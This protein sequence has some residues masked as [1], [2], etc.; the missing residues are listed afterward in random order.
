MARPSFSLFSPFSSFFFAYLR[1]MGKESLVGAPFCRLC[2]IAPDTWSSLWRRGVPRGVRQREPQTK[3]TRHNQ[4]TL[5][6]RFF[7]FSKVLFSSR[8]KKKKKV[9]ESVPSVRTRRDGRHPPQK[10]PIGTGGKRGATHRQQ[11]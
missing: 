11:T 10:D 1:G 2:V 3:A 9:E 8:E 4:R 6:Q 5:P 7:L